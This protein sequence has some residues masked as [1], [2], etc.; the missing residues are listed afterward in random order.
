MWSHINDVTALGGGGCQGI[1]AHST[2]WLVL[3]SMKM[4]G[5]FKK[6]IENCVTSF[7]DDPKFEIHDTYFFHWGVKEYK[8]KLILPKLIM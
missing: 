8:F 4:G 7:I 2:K 5:G 6:M 3:K 1:F